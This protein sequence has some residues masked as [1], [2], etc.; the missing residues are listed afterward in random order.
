MEQKMNIVR[1]KED[2]FEIILKY[3]TETRPDNMYV[4]FSHYLSDCI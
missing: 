1:A 2:K 3:I 4:S